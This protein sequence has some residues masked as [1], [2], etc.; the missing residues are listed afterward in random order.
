MAA[1]YQ[2]LVT[3]T[4]RITI[5]RQQ[6]SKNR[7]MC[8]ERNETVMHILSECSKLAQNEYKNHHDMVATM[9]ATMVHRKLC[10][11]Y[12]LNLPNTSMITERRG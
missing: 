11:K 3:K 12:G 5:L 1:Q 8:N 7:R 9:V 10:S 4:Y 6:G 2:T